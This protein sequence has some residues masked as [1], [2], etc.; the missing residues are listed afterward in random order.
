MP[1]RKPNVLYLFNIHE[2]FCSYVDDV[3]HAKQKS[4]IPE[5]LFQ[6]QEFSERKH[7]DECQYIS[8]DMRQSASF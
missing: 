2:H 4:W 7:T 6:I 5:F 1:K 3:E 8:A